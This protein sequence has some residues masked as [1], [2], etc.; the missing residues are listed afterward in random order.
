MVRLITGKQALIKRFSVKWTIISMKYCSDKLSDG[1]LTNLSV[2]Q[3]KNILKSLPIQVMNGSG[4]LLTLNQKARLIECRGLILIILDAL[5][6]RQRLMILN[7]KNILKSTFI[8][9]HFSAYI[10][11]FIQILLKQR[12][13]FLY[14]LCSS[15]MS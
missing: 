13:F 6:I 12:I 10:L 11:E 3:L 8:R 9:H 4:L 2:G 5:N 7:T 14:E 15:R 1:I